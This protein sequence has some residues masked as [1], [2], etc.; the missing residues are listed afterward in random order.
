MHGDVAVR[1]EA[2]TLASPVGQL[3]RL[4]AATDAR[5]MN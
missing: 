5:T 4:G 3:K 1:V 2:A